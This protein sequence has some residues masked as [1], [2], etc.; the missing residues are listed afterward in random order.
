MSFIRFST[1]DMKKAI[2]S[3]Q[4]TTQTPILQETTSIIA[5][6]AMM[7]VTGITETSTTTYNNGYNN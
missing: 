6:L 1:E 7:F 5:K 4:E 3:T 2:Q